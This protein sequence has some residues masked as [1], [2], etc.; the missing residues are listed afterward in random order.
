MCSLKRNDDSSA[1]RLRFLHIAALVILGVYS[2][3]ASS[4][5][6]VFPHYLMTF[7]VRELDVGF[8]LLVCLFVCLFVCLL[9]FVGFCLFC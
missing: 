8:Y 7:V 3:F 4:V 2:F 6:D 5:E 9:L 1:K